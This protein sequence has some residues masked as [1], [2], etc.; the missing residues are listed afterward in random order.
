MADSTSEL[1]IWVKIK[2]DATKALGDI[3][4]RI[5][6][7]GPVFKKMTAIGGV[8]LAGFTAIA[9]DAIHT[10]INDTKDMTLATSILQNSFD[11]LSSVQVANLKKELGTT[12]VKFTQITDAMN[13]AGES[14]INLGYDDE[15]ASIAFSKLFQVTGDTVEA[16][17]ELKLAMD[18]SA[19]SGKDLDATTQA[20]IIAHT[21]STKILKE[22]GIKAKEGASVMDVLNSAELQ[23][24]GTAET[25]SKN[26]DVQGKI[27]VLRLENIRSAV[28]K[29]LVEALQP[30]IDK[31]GP[32][33]Q[34]VLAWAEA[35]PQLI[36]TVL[37]VGAGVSAL[38]V[39]IGTLGLAIPA[40]TSGLVAMGIVTS[41]VATTTTT[42]AGGITATATATE[43]ALGPL[44]IFIIVATAVTA[45]LIALY[46]HS[47]V[48]R[49]VLAEIW[50][51]LT[52]LVG[53][54][55][56]WI[57][58]LSNNIYV[59]G[60]MDELKASFEAIWTVVEL[61]L[62]P[63]LQQLWT[64]ISTEL[65][66]A[67][68]QLWVALQPLT[69]FFQALGTLLAGTLYGAL[70]LTV[71]TLTLLTITV[72]GVLT[73]ITKLLT[74]LVGEFQG[75]VEKATSW[76]RGIGDAFTWVTDKIA[77]AINA[78]ARFND[79]VGLGGVNKMLGISGARASGGP[80]S[81]GN[82]YLV[83]ERGTEIF[84]PSVDGKIIPNH[85]I[86]GGG[87]NIYVSNSTFIGEDDLAESVMDKMVDRLK[88]NM[89][90][91]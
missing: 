12:S 25:L 75:G 64:T 15:Q 68:V 82:A 58:S 70:L 36:A 60:I 88:D 37:E 65:W 61:V 26:F 7:M 4:S 67:I 14:A 17:R 16:Q 33:V 73:G 30:M 49:D 2:D 43:L 69:P 86:G 59:I 54:M 1:N 89:K 34:G 5:E 45:G 74:L 78:F 90:F 38:A 6:D 50:T 47:Q 91:A 48:F 40:V 66:P 79:K 84:Q 57:A 56:E 13:K 11:N 27:M 3:N 87:V 71:K 29:V 81:A 9:G 32:I 20:L 8:A 52:T 18:L 19:Y 35:N 21:G 39:G 51:G 24:G 76:V 83:G 85:A 55:G 62:W 42:L 41:T 46:T 53:T 10:Y 22:F 77:D 23:V 72:A 44:G 80:V 31:I 28:G 63:A